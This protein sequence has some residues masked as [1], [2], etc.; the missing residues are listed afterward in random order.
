MCTGRGAAT[1]DQQLATFFAPLFPGATPALAGASRNAL[2]DPTLELAADYS[3]I[4]TAPKQFSSYALI[5]TRR[6]ARDRLEKVFRDSI[7]RHV[8]ASYNSP[9]S[10]MEVHMKDLWSGQ[11]RAKSP[12]AGLETIRDLRKFLL[13]LASA[14]GKCIPYSVVTVAELPNEHSRNRAARRARANELLHH[15]IVTLAM[16]LASQDG[17]LMQESELRVDR[18][19]DFRLKSTLT[20]SVDLDLGATPLGAPNYKLVDSKGFRD[21]QVADI[22][23]YIAARLIAAHARAFATSA[24]DANWPR[25]ASEFNFLLRM[26]DSMNLHIQYCLP[27]ATG[28][29]GDAAA[30]VRA[31]VPP[32]H[33]PPAGFDSSHVKPLLTIRWSNLSEVGKMIGFPTLR[34][35]PSVNSL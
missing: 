34:P 14:V 21:V 3:E 27:D 10:S 29:R 23:A 8:I 33:I 19:D 22:A 16:L 18:G 5:P 28:I 35:Y 4:G 24:R 30:W 2:P 25:L 12:F 9:V 17:V 20:E 6:Q 13:T 7:R 31:M 32:N 11:Q 26:C 1:N 15:S